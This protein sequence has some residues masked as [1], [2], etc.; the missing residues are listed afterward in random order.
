MERTTI[1][2]GGR[3][4]A[5][6]AGILAA[7]RVFVFQVLVLQVSPLHAQT[8]SDWTA[9]ISPVGKTSGTARAINGTATVTPADGSPSLAIKAETITAGTDGEGTARIST[10]ESKLRITLTWR[11]KNG[12]SRLDPSPNFALIEYRRK[13]VAEAGSGATTIFIRQDSSPP[14]HPPSEAEGEGDA[15]VVFNGPE[16]FPVGPLT[17]E[18]K[19]RT[20]SEQGKT[21][22]ETTELPALDVKVDPDWK[23]AIIPVRSGQAVL[24]FPYVLN[25]NA[26]SRYFCLAT[27]S[28]GSSGGG[29]ASVSL[30][31]RI[32]RLDIGRHNGMLGTSIEGNHSTAGQDPSYTRWLPL[33][34]SPV[35]STMPFRRANNSL[36]DLWGNLHCAYSLRVFREKNKDVNGTGNYYSSYDGKPIV[37][38]TDKPPAFV[39]LDANG[40]RLV[41]GP[42]PGFT[43][44]SKDIRSKFSYVNGVLTLT[45]AGPPGRLKERGDFTYTFRDFPDPSDPDSVEPAVLLTIADRLGNRH[46]LTYGT[47]GQPYL[48]VTDSSSSRQLLFYALDGAILR[49]VAPVLFGTEPIL[50]TELGWDGRGHLT[51]LRTFAGNAAT[52]TQTMSWE[53]VPGTDRPQRVRQNDTV[54]DY[55]YTKAPSRD[56]FGNDVYRVSAISVGDANDRSSSASPYPGAPGPSIRGTTT[57]AFGSHTSFFGGIDARTNTITDPR[58][59]QTKITYHYANPDDG[60]DNGAISAFDLYPPSFQGATGTP[61]YKQRFLPDVT[62]PT[63]SSLTLPG[64]SVDAGS[65]V[66]WE[67]LHNG[68]TGS[69]SQ[70]RDP[71]QHIWAFGWDGHRLRSVTDPTGLTWNVDYTPQGKV[72]R[73]T[74]PAGSVRSEITYNPFGQPKTLRTPAGPGG[75]TTLTYDTVTGDLLS[76][77]EPTGAKSLV[78]RPDGNTGGIVPGS[79]YDALGDP[80]AFTVFPDTGDPRTSSAPL[81]L[82]LLWNADQQVREAGL[83]GGQ[84]LVHTYANG[85]RI[86][87]ELFAPTGALLDRKDFSYDTRGRLYRIADSVGTMTRYEFDLAD[88]PVGLIDGKGNK[89]TVTYGN[90]NEVTAVTGADGGSLLYNADGSVR[91]SKDRRNVTTAFVYDAAGRVTSQ[92]VTGVATATGTPTE[93][94]SYTY[95]DANRPL[96]IVRGADRIDFAYHHANK[97]LTE[98]KTTVGGRVHTVRYGYRADGRRSSMTSIV[99][100]LVRETLYDYENSGRLFRISYPNGATTQWSYDF[101]D[102]PLSEITRTSSGTLLATWYEYGP[103]GQ[104]DDPSLAPIYLRRVRQTVNGATVA[105]YTLTHSY[106]GQLIRL[107]GTVNGQTIRTDYQYDLRGRLVSESRQRTVAGQTYGGT[108]GYSYDLADN[109]NAGT[110]GWVYNSDNRLTFAPSV[111]GMPG[112]ANLAY[113]AA[114]NCTRIDTRTLAY[115]LNGRLS[116]VRPTSGPGISISIQYDPLG[117]RFS[118]TVTDG[119]GTRSRFFDYDGND[120]IGEQ[121][122]TSISESSYTYYLGTGGGYVGATGGYAGDGQYYAYGP[123]GEMWGL[124]SKEGSWLWTLRNN[125]D[126]FG[127]RREGVDTSSSGYPRLFFNG[128]YTNPDTGWTSPTDGGLEGDYDPRTGDAL[129]AALDGRNRLYAG[130]LGKASQLAGIGMDIGD[131]A[132]S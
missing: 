85:V 74:D 89:V 64:P 41:F 124:A 31:Y 56:V 114:G 30:E 131:F 104:S 23:V 98:I 112:A 125:V 113:D 16:G 60:N 54:L 79:A 82:S 57:Y 15:K 24:D 2:Q 6:V 20:S 75:V 62:A 21:T 38:T 68:A 70:V 126:A 101:T 132:A 130:M 88:N 121:T 63:A 12:D 9:S 32:G 61:V 18:A 46:T 72:S 8:A 51:S 39:L 80:L 123:D 69:L 118:E 99:G 5:R 48:T 3:R 36:P 65:V 22:A 59:K 49:V 37:N 58:G 106:R 35:V 122:G 13:V 96:A 27:G 117:R 87:T 81:T 33:T 105:D 127:N 108:S 100:T 14:P 102:R 76:V 25:A 116:S 1:G 17:A 115:D 90:R 84:R 34:F 55:G 111:A 119:S 44:L 97:W 94:V 73:V 28:H 19:S 43:P 11:P 47:T 95:D 4:I 91:Q 40:D 110:N 120:L 45:D 83:P 77:V 10:V 103:S 129:A 78:G 7:V 66:L 42:S 109:L 92:T 128:G 26:K 107:L 29:R 93:T 50:R 71:L 67:F 53:Y 52:P 86:R